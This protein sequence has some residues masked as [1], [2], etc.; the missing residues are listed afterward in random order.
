M[1]EEKPV[2]SEPTPPK[3]K[4]FHQKEQ[5]TLKAISDTIALDKGLQDRNVEFKI[6]TNKA[7]D[8]EYHRYEDDNPNDTNP[9]RLT[10]IFTQDQIDDAIQIRKED[11]FYDF[12]EDKAE[13]KNSTDESSTTGT[14][15][16]TSRDGTI[17]VYI[18][19]NGYP[20]VAS[21]NGTF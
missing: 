15:A 20:R 8:T 9:A 11:G 5:E 14:N 1:E 17:S 7:G 19:I 2:K 3:G 10:G 4:T 12:E 16:L 21:I 6:E 18:V 13:Y